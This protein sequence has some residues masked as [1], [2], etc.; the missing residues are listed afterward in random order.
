M[1]SYAITDFG[2]R[3]VDDEFSDLDL[4]AGET[5]VRDIPQSLL[6][7][8]AAHEVLLDATATL[9]ARTRLATAQVSALQ[10]R[11]DTI[12]DAIEGEY[13]LPEEVE[14][15]PGRV[16]ELAAWKKYRVFLGRVT[17]QAI[18]PTAPTWP[19]QPEPFTNE[20]SVARTAANLS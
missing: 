9:N 19:D 4:L 2:W 1:M 12:N 6:D 7:A 5:L 10:S 20:T 18:W 3:A 13:A 11:V 16:T 14:E 15:K 17:G 8:I